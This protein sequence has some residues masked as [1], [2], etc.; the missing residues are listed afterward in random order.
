MK[1]SPANHLKGSS[2]AQGPHRPATKCRWRIL[3][4][5]MIDLINTRFDHREVA[6][7]RRTR[8]PTTSEG[9]LPNSCQD[10]EMRSGARLSE[11]RPGEV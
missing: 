8:R 7:K 6:E 9:A 3:W 11:R 10:A 4:D 2:P 5:S 1:N